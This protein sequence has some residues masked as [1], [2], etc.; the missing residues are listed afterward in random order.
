MKENWKDFSTGIMQ[1]LTKYW[2]QFLLALPR[3]ALAVVLLLAV[4]FIASFISRKCGTTCKVSR[5]FIA[6]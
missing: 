6:G 4:L 3:I 1:S 5:I 2:H